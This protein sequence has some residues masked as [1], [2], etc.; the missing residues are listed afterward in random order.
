MKILTTLK[1]I[2][3]ALEDGKE[4]LI[5]MR[6]QN[7][8]FIPSIFKMTFYTCFLYQELYLLKY[9]WTANKNIQKINSLILKYT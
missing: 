6:E 5:L 7:R 4:A 9:I 2:K 1:K 3:K 8:F